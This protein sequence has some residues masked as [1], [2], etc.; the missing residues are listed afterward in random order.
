MLCITADGRKLA[1]YI[2]LKRKTLPKV[3]VKGVIFQAQES[4]WMDQ[5]LVLEWINRVWQKCPGALLNLHNMVILDSVHGHTTEEVKKTFKSR[6]TDQVI[7]PGGL[8]SML[9]PLDVCI[10]R[11]FKAVLKEQYTRWMAV[12]E[13]EFTPMGKIKRPDVEQLCEWIR[14]AWARILLAFI[15]KSFKKCDISNKFDGTEDDYLWDS[16]PD[17]ASSVDDDDKSSGEEYL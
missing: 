14:E 12:G 16:D 1:P 7:I 13:H 8:T 10:N 9:Q 15:E 4:G 6:N 3:N 17:H 2:V 5:T 11:P